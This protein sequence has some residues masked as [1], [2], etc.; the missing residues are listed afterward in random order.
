M[1]LWDLAGKVKLRELC[2]HTMNV[3]SV[4]FSLDGYKLASG[5][6]DKTVCIWDAHSGQLERQ[7]TGFGERVLSVTVSPDGRMIATA[8]GS[9]DSRMG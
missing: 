6:E 9:P 2:G 5:S 8:S 1:F 7:L 4:A 3:W